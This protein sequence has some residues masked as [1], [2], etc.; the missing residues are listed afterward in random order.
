MDG[1]A[2]WGLVLSEKQRRSKILEVPSV[3]RVIPHL[4]QSFDALCY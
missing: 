4:H 3:D 2:I 1:E